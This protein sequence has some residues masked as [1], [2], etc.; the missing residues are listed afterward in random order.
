[1][2]PATIDEAIETLPVPSTIGDRK[3]AFIFSP[4]PVH[5]GAWHIAVFVAQPAPGQQ[6][7]S[8]TYRQAEVDC[9]F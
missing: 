3:K 9:S 6:S 8:W 1:M 7:P 5:G 2:Y 4:H